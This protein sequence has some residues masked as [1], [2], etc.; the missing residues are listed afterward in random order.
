LTP[1]TGMLKWVEK[2]GAGEG[3]KNGFRYTVKYPADRKINF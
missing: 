1:E 2:I 3:R